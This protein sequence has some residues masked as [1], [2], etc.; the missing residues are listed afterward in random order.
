[1]MN[2]VDEFGQV[3]YICQKLSC[4]YEEALVKRRK[5]VD[6]N[7]MSPTGD[8]QPATKKVLVKVKAL[9]ASSAAG[10]KVVV[11]KK[12]GKVPAE[13]A[14]QWETVVEV[15]RPSKLAGRRD[16]SHDSRRE[17]RPVRPGTPVQRRE[18][19]TGAYTGS[20]DGGTTFADLLAASEKRKKE[21]DGKRK[22]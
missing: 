9:P 14:E 12:S 17:A 7:G 13:S 21:R 8:T 3:H 18:P 4:S 20:S 5:P 6:G 10:K 11:V 22:K 19:A 16:Y 15:I 1:M 2:I